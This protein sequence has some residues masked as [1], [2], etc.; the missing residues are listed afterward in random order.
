[1]D[2]LRKPFL[3]IAIV[4][5]GIVVL[6]EV[7]QTSLLGGWP[8][9]V[10][11]LIAGQSSNPTQDAARSL[12]DQLLPGEV[13]DALKNLDSEQREQLN[14][15][16]Q[17][18][19]PPGLGIPYMA[20]VD[21]IVLFTTLLIGL[22][23]VIPARIQGRVQGVVTLIFS[24]LIIIAAIGMILAAIAL[25]TTMVALLLAIPFGTIVYLI[26]YGWFDTGSARV[27]LSLLMFLKLAFVVALLLAQQRF[28]TN[29]GLVL[30]VVTAIAATIVVTFLHGLVPSFL[31][32]ITDAVGGIVVAVLAGLWAI[33]L[34]VGAIISVV[35]AIRLKA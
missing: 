27:V 23:L 17:A 21:G 11:A 10:A 31:V 15:L 33:F 8:T 22:S 29:I 13:K 35:T 32:S 30:I 7:G 25:L 20:L 6:I 16:A 34:L 9:R 28:V 18:E 24:I 19:R 1:M 12:E 3:I 4:L 26:V 2:T 5:I 14:A